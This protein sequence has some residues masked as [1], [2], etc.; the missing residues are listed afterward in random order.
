MVLPYFPGRQV[1]QLLEFNCDVL[2]LN[3][4]VGHA[5]R[6]DPPEQ[7]KPSSQAMH[8]SAELLLDEDD[9]Y[10]PG[11]QGMQ[12]ICEVPFEYSLYFPTAQLVRFD[13]PG[14]KNP[15]SHTTQAASLVAMPEILP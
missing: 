12:S 8:A 3:F 15:G 7:M 10:F 11:E 6:L 14:Q 5:I 2:L 1:L 13:P 9:P 4:P